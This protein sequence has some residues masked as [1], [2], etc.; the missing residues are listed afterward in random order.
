MMYLCEQ[1]EIMSHVAFTG[2]WKCMAKQNIN[3]CHP[4]TMLKN[5]EIK[6]K[7]CVLHLVTYLKQTPIFECCVLRCASYKGHYVK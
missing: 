4:N 2:M 7:T 6:Y 1:R 3:G 5:K